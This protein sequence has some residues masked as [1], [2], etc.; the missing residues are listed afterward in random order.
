MQNYDLIV[1]GGNTQSRKKAEQ[2]QTKRGW[3]IVNEYMETAQPNVWSLGDADGKYPFKHVA[4]YE[5]QV[6]YRNAFL[7]QAMKVENNPVPHAVF[8][9]AR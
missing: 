8:S 1:I 6:I 4:N 7:K 9:G 5:A 2:R 3:I